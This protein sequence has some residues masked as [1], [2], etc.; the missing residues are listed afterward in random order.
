MKDL[1]YNDLIN[2]SSLQTNGQL[3]LSFDLLEDHIL[4]AAF[5]AH[6]LAL[7]YKDAKWIQMGYR[8]WLN[9]H[10]P[11]RLNEVRELCFNADETTS[12]YRVKN[13]SAF[14]EAYEA[15]ASTLNLVGDIRLVAAFQKTSSTTDDDNVIFVYIA[16]RV[17]MY[18][19]GT[20][21]E[22]LSEDD[23]K[24]QEQLRTSTAVVY[25]ARELLPGLDWKWLL[26]ME[27]KAQS[28]LYTKKECMDK[29][30]VLKKYADG[31]EEDLLH[32]ILAYLKTYPDN[33]KIYELKQNSGDFDQ[34][35]DELSRDLS[36]LIPAGDPTY[37]YLFKIHPD[38]S[39]A[40]NVY[41]I[42]Y[43]SK[44]NDKGARWDNE[45]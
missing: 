28:T 31:I 17:P 33:A 12:I 6:K 37:A 24:E 13:H 5:D 45:D 19:N 32:E 1:T 2:N 21:D 30:S 40:D 3:R 38:I 7:R 10:C 25:S 34:E 29:V 27:R 26:F 23:K 39:G 15:N 18:E 20:F 9:N 44:Y 16:D 43:Y 11:A 41:F 22:F 8:S 36:H 4:E 42:G 14:T 35:L